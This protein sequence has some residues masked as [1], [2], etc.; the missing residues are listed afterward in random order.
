MSWYTFSLKK[1]DSVGYDE[2]QD[3]FTIMY[4][5]HELP[6]GMSL[7]VKCGCAGN[8]NMFF[9]QVPQDLNTSDE[10]FFRR[11]SPSKCSDPSHIGLSL[12]VG[13][14]GVY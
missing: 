6:R 14:A 2:S 12:L 7:W 11:F 5:A 10:A 8:E 9:A 13:N 3:L 4:L 1:D